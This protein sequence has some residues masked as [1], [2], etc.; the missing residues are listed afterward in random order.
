MSEYF[1]YFFFSSCIS[2]SLLSI[3][4]VL[5]AAFFSHSPQNLASFQMTIDPTVNLI[6]MNLCR[7]FSFTALHKAKQT[8]LFLSV[9]YAAK[10]LMVGK[11]TPNKSKTLSLLQFKLR[12]IKESEIWL[13]SS[14]LDFSERQAR[15]LKACRKSSCE[16]FTLQEPRIEKKKHSYW[17]TLV[18][19]TL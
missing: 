4:H 1:T 17:L 19:D 16:I 7:A 15:I 14:V 13:I 5:S 6:S 8:W 18:G 11:K 10:A 3:H 2:T 12:V 9:V